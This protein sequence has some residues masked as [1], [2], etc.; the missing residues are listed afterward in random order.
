M[1]T[2]VVNFEANADDLLG[3]LQ[4]IDTA[5]DRATSS[6][7]GINAQAANTSQQ[8]DGVK[9]AAQAAGGR[10]GEMAGRIEN[11]GRALAS[12]ASNPVA[13]AIAGV[14]ALGAGAAIAGASVVAAFV[15]VTR[16]AQDAADEIAGLEG[17]G[18]TGEQIAAIEEANAALDS[19]SAVV[20]GL[21]VQLGAELAPTVT[22]VATVITALGL[23][24]QDAFT[25]AVAN[26]DLGREAF[27]RLVEFGLN[28]VNA[29]MLTLLEGFAAFS[30][31]AGLPI[32][33]L[34]EFTAN[35]REVQVGNTVLTATAETTGQALGNYGERAR[36]LIADLQALKTATGDVDIVFAQTA[37]DIEYLG[38]V[39]ESSSGNM[40]SLQD[41]L[42]Q[43]ALG[44]QAFRDATAEAIEQVTRL[45]KRQAAI[46]ALG[47]ALGGVSNI[48]G[49]V[50]DA[51]RAM[52]DAFTTFGQDA[53]K[54]A[55]ASFVAQK[56]A[57]IADAVIKTSQSIMAALTIPPPVGPVLA[58]INAATGATQI[59]T[60]AA[61]T[62]EGGGPTPTA[63]PTGGGAAGAAAAAASVP[64]VTKGFQEDAT[65]TRMTRGGM[66]YRHRD[67]DVVARDGRRYPGGAFDAGG[68][69]GQNRYDS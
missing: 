1:A 62:F 64:S 32:A 53:A 56:A 29:A 23:M 46:E 52:G 4:G 51:A 57:G 67:L 37:E 9:F 48:A 50:G 16:A 38:S 5:A 44:S 63:P 12:F 27:V 19:I 7:G 18:I 43:A 68:G 3:A 54:A 41:A 14:T 25:S 28:P 21:V 8:L 2:V 24:V 42:F 10:V 33:S 49:T 35:L 34:E 55:K 40:L 47:Q 61:T 66:T 22:E 59:A 20:Q 58:G 60:I 30:R 6:M 45:A 17:L 15:G 11:A 31:A 26:I 39:G 69:T 65:G 13:L 36:A